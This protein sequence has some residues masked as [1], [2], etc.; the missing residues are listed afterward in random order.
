VG[1]WAHVSYRKT[2]CDSE[3]GALS[4]CAFVNCYLIHISPKFLECRCVSAAMTFNR[5]RDPAALAEISSLMG[6][7]ARTV[8]DEHLPKVVKRAVHYGSESSCQV[9]K[10]I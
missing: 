7:A 9:N 4:T 8:D 5:T 1:V 3:Q 6:A 2:V 10:S